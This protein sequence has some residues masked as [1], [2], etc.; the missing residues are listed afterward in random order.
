M[1]SCDLDNNCTTFQFDPK[2]KICK[3]CSFGII[4]SH[5]RDEEDSE[6]IISGWCTKVK[7]ELKNLLTSVTGR[8]APK[9]WCQKES[10]SNFPFDLEGENVTHYSPITEQGVTKCTF[11][12]F[13]TTSTNTVDRNDLQECSRC[14]GNIFFFIRNISEFS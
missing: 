4:E 11:K 3:K 13:K 10:L 7:D 14:H 8:V 5:S 9:Y 1:L 6:Q 12:R 2:T